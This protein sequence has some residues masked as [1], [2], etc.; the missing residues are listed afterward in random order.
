MRNI[1]IKA[2]LRDRGRV[3]VELARL[4]ARD[5][6]RES[7]HDIFFRSARGRLKLRLSSRDGASLIAYARGDAPVLRASDYELVRVEDGVEMQLVLDT[8]LERCGEV[9]KE[10]HLYWVD[11]VRVHL[12]R[13][14]GLG[15][16]LELEAVVDAAHP[17]AACRGHAAALLE[18]FGVA[19]G[20]RVAV[21]YVDLAT[22]PSATDP[23]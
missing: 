15:D 19:P 23:R 22:H 18:R 16:F 20:D 6:G 21:A 17:E 7:Q 2:R 9:R 1:E 12:D 5:A 11:N 3:E 14:E 13:V 4:G 10:R 8:A